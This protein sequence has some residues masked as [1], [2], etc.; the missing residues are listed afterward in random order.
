M[1]AELPR[2]LLNSAEMRQFYR[3]SILIGDALRSAEILGVRSV[4]DQVAARL[5]QEPIHFH[6]PA[7]SISLAAKRKG[8]RQILV[9]AVAAAAVAFVALVAVAPQMQG[10]GVA[11]MIAGVSSGLTG[12]PSAATM[13]SV[14]SATPV[15]LEDPRLRELLEAHGSMSIRPVSAEVR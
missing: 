4:A 7:S 15:M 12:S 14:Q 10:G 13:V 11:E 5:A 8:P 6:R 9:G 3:E 2:Q 1:G